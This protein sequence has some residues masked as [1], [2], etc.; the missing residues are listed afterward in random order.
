[1]TVV[2]DD[3][4][5]VGHVDYKSQ[6]DLMIK[7]V[8]P[9]DEGIYECQVASTDRTMR[10]LVS[11]TVLGNAAT[12]K[13]LCDGNYY[14]IIVI[15]ENLI[16]EHHESDKQFWCISGQKLCRVWYGFKL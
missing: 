13:T 12:I 15:F 10:R 3:R 4:L 16:Q 14:G 6:W 2:A 9:D 7:N 11:L 8:Q 5:Q 1:M